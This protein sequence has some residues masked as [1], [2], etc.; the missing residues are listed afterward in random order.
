MFR[1]FDIQGNTFYLLY[2]MIFQPQLIRPLSLSCEV[3]EPVLRETGALMARW[4][5]QVCK[6]PTRMWY[7]VLTEHHPIEDYQ[8][9]VRT[10]IRSGYRNFV[11]EQSKDIDEITECVMRVDSRLGFTQ[12]KSAEGVRKHVQSLPREYQWWLLK[13]RKEHSLGYVLLYVAGD[14][15]QVR[16]IHIVDSAKRKGAAYFVNYRLSEIFLKDKATQMIIYGLRSLEHKTKVQQ[17]L[18]EKMFYRK[19]YVKIKVCLSPAGKLIYAVFRPLMFLLKSLPFSHA[20][21]IYAFVRFISLVQADK[22]E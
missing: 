22:K 20:R 14:Q 9:R 10:Y 3:V 6:E 8:S 2:G 5:E 4:V 21:K 16:T 12:K 1:E 11:F 15:V 18:E 13:D 7:V 19:L 17:W